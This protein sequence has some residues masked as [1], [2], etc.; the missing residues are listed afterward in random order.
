VPRLLA[1]L[2]D[3]RA[4]LCTMR[5]RW[6]SL[7][8]RNPLPIWVFDR[9]S[10]R[11][12]AVNDTAVERY[13]YSRAE[14]LSMTILDLRPP[15]DAAE[16]LAYVRAD[17][18]PDDSGRAWRHRLKDG[19]II[20]VNNAGVDILFD[21]RPACMVLVRDIT[22]RVVAEAERERFQAEIAHRATHDQLTGLPNRE[23]LCT[24]LEAAM[25]RARAEGQRL[26]VAFVDLD[27]F[28]LVNDSFGHGSGDAVLRTI[29]HR[30]RGRLRPGEAVARF[31]GDE[32]VLVLEE[33]DGE[34]AAGRLVRDI[35]A[36][37]A[38]PVEI[39]RVRHALTASIG[40]C[41]F[42]HDGGDVES[43]LRRADLAMYRAKHDGRNCA[44]AYHADL[45]SAAS[46]RLK[47]LG[48]LRDALE[49]DQFM[50][51]YQPIFDTAGTP[52]ALEALVRWRHPHR[53]VVPPSE[54]IPACEESGLVVAL[55]RQVLAH[56]ARTHRRLAD[57]GWGHL[58][59][60]VNVSATQ[61]TPD[62]RSDI[63]RLVREHALPA[64]ALELELT[65]TVLMAQPERALPL[66]EDLSA[67]GVRLVIDDFGTGH[68][69]LAYLRRLPI[70]GLKIDRSFIAGLGVEGADEAIC[71]AV[72]TLTRALGVRV[73]AEGVECRRQLDW[74]RARGCNEVQGFLL[75]HPQ[76][77]DALLAPGGALHAGARVEG[78]A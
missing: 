41:R 31:G 9:E 3:A 21:G 39:A 50:L 43:L 6:H 48:E 29:A 78:A 55:G 60:A 44:V 49:R 62:L 58:R 75:G 26:L 23:H 4:R 38:Q 67:L 18:P 76:P 20:Y 70:H 13:G 24:L 42:P 28:K 25:A 64:G 36:H 34:D 66:L 65:E 52:V 71:T 12:L 10:L 35:A 19:R 47:L 45:Q 17:E 57:A 68:S 46:A 54:F 51:E 77:I 33:H 14:F 5:A 7:F 11:I 15:E 61:F 72:M 63:E 8:H 27:D 1:A 40:W 37:V 69:S 73:V 30:M 16:T 2:Q 56:A 22:E 53:G 59:V 74:L 32:F